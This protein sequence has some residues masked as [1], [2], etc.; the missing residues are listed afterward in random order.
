MELHDPLRQSGPG[1]VSLR[2]QRGN[3]RCEEGS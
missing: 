2:V 1:P 3:L